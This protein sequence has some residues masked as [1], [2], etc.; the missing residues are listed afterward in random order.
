LLFFVDNFLFQWIDVLPF[1]L[2]NGAEM[3]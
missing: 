3:P 1:E 2:N